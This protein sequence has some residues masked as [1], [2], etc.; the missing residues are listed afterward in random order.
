MPIT[1]TE[2][3]LRNVSDIN[4][5]QPR[6]LVSARQLRLL[7]IAMQFRLYL[8]PNGIRTVSTHLSLLHFWIAVRHLY[9]I[10]P[11]QSTIARCYIFIIP[12]CGSTNIGRFFSCFFCGFSCTFIL[13]SCFYT[14]YRTSH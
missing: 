8:Y 9:C 5:V 3:Y 13:N 7:H 1:P 2:H 14:Y 6:S 10:F 11:M 4:Y 12:F